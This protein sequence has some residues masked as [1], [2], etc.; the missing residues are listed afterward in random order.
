MEGRELGWKVRNTFVNGVCI[1]S[2]EAEGK[3]FLNEELHSEPVG[4]YKTRPF[5][6]SHA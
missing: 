6:P 4:F 2:N 1:Y 5:A 3:R